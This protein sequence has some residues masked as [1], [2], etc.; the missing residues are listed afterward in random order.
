MWLVCSG[1]PVGSCV[2]PYPLCL[3]GFAAFAAPVARSSKPGGLPSSTAS[4]FKQEWVR[5]GFN[6]LFS[7]YYIQFS[8]FR[9]VYI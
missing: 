4:V 1:M 3:M 6:R 7:S 2:A 9:N 5:L 8:Y